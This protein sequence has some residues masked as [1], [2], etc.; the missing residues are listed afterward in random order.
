MVRHDGKR[1]RQK[2]NEAKLGIS[3]KIKKSKGDKKL[4]IEEKVTAGA[5]PAIFIDIDGV[6]LKG[7]GTTGQGIDVLEGSE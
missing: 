7:T 5:L 3:K 6:I 4:Q 1:L 2:I